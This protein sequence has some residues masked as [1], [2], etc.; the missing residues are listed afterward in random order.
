MCS[1][2]RARRASRGSSPSGWTA[3]TSRAAAR[4]DGSRSRT[5]SARTCGSA[6][7]CRGRGVA[8]SGPVMAGAKRDGKAAEVEVGGRVVRVSNPDKVLWPKTGFT[9]SDLVD[10]FASIAPVLLPHLEGRMLT[11]KRYPNGVEGNHF[12]EKNC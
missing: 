1:R 7:G 5:S 3:P 10:Y 12:Y 2:R 4:G 9:K 11:L 6:A 8:R